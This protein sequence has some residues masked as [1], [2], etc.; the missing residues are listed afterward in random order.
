[1]NYL[2]AKCGGIYLITLPDGTRYIGRTADFKSRYRAHIGFARRNSHRI[3][4]I[5][6]AFNTYGEKG[7]RMSVLL[8]CAK[9]YRR[10][11]EAAAIEQHAPEH[12]R[13]RPRVHLIRGTSRGE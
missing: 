9:R 13:I 10:M 2:P 3:K 5:Q 4:G 12:N 6:R 1:M 8:I 11:F 7:V